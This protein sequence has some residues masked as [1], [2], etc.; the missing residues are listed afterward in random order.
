LD[1]L[2]E[3][4][5]K[6][7]PLAT[8][9]STGDEHS[10]IHRNL[11]FRKVLTKLGGGAGRRVPV[12]VMYTPFFPSKTKTDDFVFVSL[13]ANQQFLPVLDVVTEAGRA[14]AYRQQF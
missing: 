4:D 9:K 2:L 3:L 5:F 6:H 14:C 12:F 10:R 13:R 7:I 1:T 11:N 8:L